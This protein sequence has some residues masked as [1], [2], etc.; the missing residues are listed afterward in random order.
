[1]WLAEAITACGD[2]Q[3]ARK[4]LREALGLFADLADASYLLGFGVVTL[5]VLAKTNAGAH[6]VTLISFL[7]QLPRQDR[8]N[9]RE[10]EILLVLKRQMQL[11]LPTDLY[12]MAWEQG[13]T[14]TL[15]DM[16]TQLRILI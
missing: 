16:L 13:Q 2:Y 3:E 6:I 1:V 5:S 14:L 7:E 4:H 15:E 9:P 10:R 12:T 11:A 8:L